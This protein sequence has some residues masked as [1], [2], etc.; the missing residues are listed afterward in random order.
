ML[1][2]QCLHDGAGQGRQIDDEF[3]LEAALGVGERVG[4]HQSP[5]R[6]GVEDFDGLSRQGFEHIVGTDGIAARHILDQP[7]HAHRID[8]RLALGQRHHGAG[9][10]GR[11]AHVALHAHH[12]G[13]PA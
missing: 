2:A 8:P 7:D 4:Q 5:F 11:P 13:C 6:V 1:E 9:D 3:R 12:A 10:G